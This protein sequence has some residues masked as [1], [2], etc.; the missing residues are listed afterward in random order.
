MLC[1][2][3]SPARLIS[4]MSK[5]IPA[6]HENWTFVV[7]LARKM[8]A[9]R[10]D[11]EDLAQDVFERWLRAAPRLVPGTNPRAWMSVVLRNLLIDQVRRRKVAAASAGDCSWSPAAEAE[12]APWWLELDS[13]EVIRLLDE[14]PRAQRATFLRFELEGKS[15]EEIARELAIS[16]NTVGVHVFRARARLRE[17]LCARRGG[18]EAAADAEAS[19]RAA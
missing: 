8:S 16:K 17:L 1:T 5:A 2:P 19:A 6:L 3:R 18:A 13:G 11:A 12:R 4:T 7:G 9:G 15:Y 14:L 10:A